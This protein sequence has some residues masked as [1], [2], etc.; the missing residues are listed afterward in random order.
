[1]SEEIIEKWSN[2]KLTESEQHE[3]KIDAVDDEIMFR[4]GKQCQIGILVSEKSINREA[5]KSTM[6]NIWKPKRGL[7]FREVGDN[8][9]LIEFQKIKIS[10]VK[11]G[12]RW[13]FDHKLF[14]LNTFDGFSAPKDI[15]FNKEYMWVQLHNNLLGGMTWDF[16]E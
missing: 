11:K 16:G 7:Q 4:R 3:V 12:R 14:Y 8:F 9:F 1:M 15:I 13:T 5:F 10:K 2:L 6:Q